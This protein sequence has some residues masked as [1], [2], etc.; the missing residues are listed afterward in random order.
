M[1]MGRPQIIIDSAS[2]FTGEEE[3]EGISEESESWSTGENPE[4]KFCLA[5]PYF[6]SYLYV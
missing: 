6:H 5:T 4:D 1:D 3:E 2:D